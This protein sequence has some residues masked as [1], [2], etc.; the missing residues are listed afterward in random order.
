MYLRVIKIYLTIPHVSNIFSYDTKIV[1]NQ[2]FLVENCVI[3]GGKSCK[4]SILN[5]LLSMN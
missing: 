4:S 3:S 2:Y 1:D 5:Q